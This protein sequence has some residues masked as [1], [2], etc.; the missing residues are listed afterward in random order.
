MANPDKIQRYNITA[1]DS[2]KYLWFR[3]AKVGTRTIHSLL[4]QHTQITLDRS[5]VPYRGEK[6]NDYFKFAFVR[7]PWGRLVSAY[8]DKV[9]NNQKLS[10][11]RPVFGEDFDTFVRFV[12]KQD[13]ATADRHIALQT[14]LMPVEELS[15]LG[16]FENF[17]SDL[18]NVLDR[19]QVVA[20]I[21][22]K[23]PTRH[24]K[25]TKYYTAHTKKLI[26]ELY[27]QDIDAFGY[28]FD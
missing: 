28:Q 10:F 3:A 7:N 12:A 17:T 4:K 2:E 13:L 24:K 27:R 5:N 9:V 25:Y 16:R 11:Y 8:I 1:S 6:Y 23:N 22:H 26:A 20:P 19:L 15:F 18:S 14:T 21:P